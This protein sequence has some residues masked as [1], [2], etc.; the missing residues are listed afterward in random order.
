MNITELIVEQLEQ[1]HKVVIPGIGTLDSV[2]LNAHHDPASR[3]YYPAS[4]T[5]AFSGDSSDETEI[6]KVLAERECV[7]EDVAKQM[8]DNYVDALTDKIRRTGSHTMGRLGTLTCSDKKTF[9][10]TVAEGLVLDAGNAGEV[11]IEEVKIY[12]HDNE[13]DPF[14]QF[15]AE[16]EPEPEPVAEPEPEPVAEPEPEPEPAT[17]P[18]PEPVVEP[19][20]ETLK[21]WKADLQKLDEMPKSEKELKREAK[22]K[23]KAE[24]ER[25]KAEKK[26]EEERIR[27]EKIA[28]EEKRKAEERIAKE[29]AEAEKR[30]A[31]ERRRAE[32]ELRRAEKKA[33]EERRRAEKQAEAARAK[34]DKE[35]EK[36]RIRAEKKAAALAAL[37]ASKEA[38]AAKASQALADKEAAAALAAAERQRKEAEKEAAQREKELQRQ[39]EMEAA[40]KERQQHEA[41]K[42]RIEAEK[43]AEKARIE[44]EKQAEKARIEAEKERIETE[45]QA[46]K[47]RIEAEKKAEKEHI[48]AEKA[49]KEAEKQA[50]KAR[51]E[52]EKQA[53]K[54]AKKNKQLADELM[55]PAP[56]PDS[57][58]DG[59]KR[60]GLW[61]PLLLVLLVL[62]IAGGAYYLLRNQLPQQGTQM[63][64]SGTAAKQL[65]VPADNMFTYNTDM[66]Q[67]TN[68]EVLLSRDEVCLFM[69][70]YINQYL[71]DRN[72]SSARV[73]MMDRVRQYAGE[74][75]GELMGD[76]FAV[77]RLIPYDDYIY[78]YCEPALKQTHANRSRV[79]VQKELMDYR[80]LDNMLY[81]M[82]DDLGLQPDGN[83]QKSAAEVKEVKATEKKAVEQ[84]KAAAQTGESPVYVY[85][86]KGSKQGYDVIA[87]FYLNKATA[88]KMTARLH[89]LG[90]DAYIIEFNDLYYVSM[91]SASTQT[92][93]D[94]LLKHIKS[95]YDG[96]AVIKKW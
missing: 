72:Y 80:A 60:H 17:E 11:P 87:G 32:E 78:S 59:K 38:K 22:E 86:E 14:A 25:L 48:E 62:V 28:E 95:W 70:D 42:A 47:A 67:Y 46:E 53:A 2:M 88:A 6:V 7:S 34:A 31:E 56:A 74:R 68:R 20:S 21:G 66:L 23:A 19:Q 24:K 3:I 93:A 61:L 64:Q 85:V 57:D 96:D 1:G 9:G 33:E 63:A 73:P 26:A 65:D 15:D 36:E 39:A 35:A 89:D 8:W 13:E 4:R 77:Q 82:V 50:E 30:E 52:A 45:K 29:R 71:A 92:S 49:R 94:A 54:Q 76:R 81:Q 51:K 75:L 69:R 5:I 79:T 10:F 12:N 18:E 90:C 58:N 43:Q 91:G 44:A 84:K 37:A 41:E 83:G 27:L 55:S 16:P 40:E